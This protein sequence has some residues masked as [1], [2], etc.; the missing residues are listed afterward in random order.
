[1]S[2]R[3]IHFFKNAIAFECGNMSA[4]EWHRDGV[5]YTRSEYVRLD[6]RLY[7]GDE[8]Q[9]LKAKY[10]QYI[11]LETKEIVRYPGR[12]KNTIIRRASRIT[13]PE[14]T[15]TQRERNLL[16][17]Y[18][19]RNGLRGAL[20]M[21]QILPDDLSQ[22]EKLECHRRW[23]EL[24]HAYSGRNTTYRSDRLMVLAGLIE[25]IGGKTGMSNV[26][27]LW[28][29]TLPFDLLWA[30]VTSLSLQPEPALAPSWSW[31]SARGQVESLLTTF[32]AA[33]GDDI[34]GTTTSQIH[35]ETAVEHTGSSNSLDETFSSTQIQPDSMG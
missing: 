2:R 21:L 19:A 27:G 35:I 34:S 15:S 26:E 24:V 10:P 12:S 29:T 22:A 30:P 23:Y 14:Y 13:N 28:E 17:A 33:H 16:L 31:V 32:R 20:E 6:G 18:S 9:V 25:L 4:S 5:P 11:S 8:L 1:M 3:V 7:S